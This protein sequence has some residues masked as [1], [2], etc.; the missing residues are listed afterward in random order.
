[1]AELS[2]S[3]DLYNGVP[4]HEN[5]ETSR[6]AAESIVHGIGHLQ[7]LVLEEIMFRGSATDDE[8]EVNLGLKHQTVSARRREL[9]LKGLVRD[10][11]TTRETR[12][13]RKATVWVLG[14]DPTFCD[15]ERPM[16]VPSKEEI[17][18]SLEALRHVYTFAL[19]HGY[20]GHPD[21]ES[22]V[23]VINWLKRLTSI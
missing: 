17:A 18:A 23:K 14:Y 10:S 19:Q 3:Y 9:V 2:G 16:V 22:M 1:M 6:Q 4:P 12:S 7:R 5:S 11:G 8:L 21:H 20:R 15:D 13:G